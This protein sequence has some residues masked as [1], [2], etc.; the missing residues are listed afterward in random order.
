MTGGLRIAEAGDEVTQWVSIHTILPARFGYA[1]QLATIRQF[2]ETDA[3]EIE[4]AHKAMTTTA[5][6]TAANRSG[7]ELRGAS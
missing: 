3:A 6:P 4:V 2:A 7:H 5:T 1:W